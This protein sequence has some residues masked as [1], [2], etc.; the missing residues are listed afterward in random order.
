MEFM[1]LINLCYPGDSGRVYVCST[2]PEILASS[3]FY[4]SL[5]IEL[6]PSPQ[7]NPQEKLI[8]NVESWMVGMWVTPSYTI[9]HLIKKDGNSTW[10]I[11]YLNLS[12]AGIQLALM[13]PW[14]VE[15]GRRWKK[16]KMKPEN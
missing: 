12:L 14:R 11:V 5:K 1:E 15:V 2:I 9:S 3:S 7:F 10:P 8:D 13:Q 4:R 16:K 6:S